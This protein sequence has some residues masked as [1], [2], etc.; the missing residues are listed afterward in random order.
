MITSASYTATI[1]ATNSL[2][3]VVA[4][5]WVTITPFNT[6][7]AGALSTQF[8]DRLVTYTLMVTN[9]N[10]SLSALG[11]VISG[12]IPVNTELS[13]TN[14]LSVSMGGDYGHGCVKLGPIT[15]APG[16]HVTLTWT[17]LISR[18]SGEI[19]T[20]SHV[21]SDNAINALEIPSLRI[22]QSILPGIFVR[23]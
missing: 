10:E 5:T 11:V 14:G 20:L 9:E 19:A 7:L 12:S 16:A 8:K 2:S 21:S 23:F 3:S 4:T 15:L 6:D 1:T 18:Y 17:V 13:S 22:Y